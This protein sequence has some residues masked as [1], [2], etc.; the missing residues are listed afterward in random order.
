[1][2]EFEAILENKIQPDQCFSVS[3][4]QAEFRM[5]PGPDA[6]PVKYYKN[7]Y[8]MQYPV[9]RYSDCVP[10]RPKREATEKQVEAGK[11]LAAASRLNSKRGRAATEAK[12]WLDANAVFID[13]ETTGLEGDDQVIE[14]AV[15][16]A[17]GHVLLDTRLR[18]SVLINPEAQGVH[19]I[20]IEALS[21]EPSWTEIAP[22]LRLV[23]EGRQVVAFN[24]DFDSRLLQQTAEAYGDDYW[25]W[26]VKEHCA[27]ALAAK[28]L[29]A[30][31]RHGS[32]SLAAAAGEAGV[33]QVD[34]H[35]A[36]GDALTALRV[37]R[38]IAAYV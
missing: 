6:V 35:N 3:R 14:I 12:A 22:F 8:G 1:M 18:P 26:D 28:A 16:D 19:G 20:S 4:L 23:L 27:M 29:G 24:S 21:G 34:A 30:K 36:R 31:N 33:V 5:K 25:S 2:S 9:Y 10:M 38:A 15:I 37:V 11:Q 13:T 17:H 32:I 7:T